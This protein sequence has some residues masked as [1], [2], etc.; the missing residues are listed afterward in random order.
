[1]P[2]TQKFSLMCDE[3]RREDNGKFIIVGA[4]TPDMA[5]TQIPFVMPILTFFVWLESD[6]PGNFPFRLKLEHLE[7]GKTLA[8][9]MGMMGFPK[10]GA[11]VS[12][13]RLG[14]IQFASPGPYMFSLQF[15]GQPEKLL[16][17]FSVILNVA[18]QGGQASG[19]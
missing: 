9:G 17:Q 4:Y 16:T 5:I 6:R 19:A 3:V 7:S 18:P 11:G 1:M 12:A 14:G 10:P 13:I 15:E 2:V 8:E